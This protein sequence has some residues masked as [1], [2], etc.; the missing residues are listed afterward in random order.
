MTDLAYEKDV[1]QLVRAFLRVHQSEDFSS[2][3][4]SELVASIIAGA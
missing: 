3:F 1:R 4:C 2:V